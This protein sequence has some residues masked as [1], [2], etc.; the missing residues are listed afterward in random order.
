MS[1]ANRIPNVWTASHGTIH[2]PS[3]GSRRECF[4]S[5]VLRVALESAID[6]RSAT[7]VPRV[8]FLILSFAN[9]VSTLKS[10]S[11]CGAGPH[12]W[13]LNQQLTWI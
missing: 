12:S 4:N 1:M 11:S 8:W 7:V 2:S 9:L 5:P 3:P 10:G 13:R 6:A